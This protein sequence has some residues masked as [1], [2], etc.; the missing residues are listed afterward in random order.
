MIEIYMCSVFSSGYK[1]VPYCPE[2]AP[3]PNFER[4]MVLRVTPTLLNS[5]VVNPKVGPL[6]S[7]SCDC[8]GGLWAPRHQ[9]S[10]FRTHPSVASF[11]VFFPCS[12][13]FAYCKRRLNAAATRLRV[14]PLCSTIQLSP[15]SGWPRR[16]ADELTMQSHGS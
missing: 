12:T 14:G 13:K 15:L 5:R 6:S 16:I 1:H 8:S 10:K 11:A 4:F 2:Q 3:P 9:A 7:H